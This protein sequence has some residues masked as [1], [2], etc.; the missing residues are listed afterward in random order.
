MPPHCPFSS[1][2]PSL[3][4]S[5]HR[6][7]FHL[8]HPPSTF[9]FVHLSSSTSFLP[10]FAHPSFLYSSSPPYI[11]TFPF[12]TSSLHLSL[13]FPVILFHF[14]PP[15]LF[16][17]SDL[18][19]SLL[20]SFLRESYVHFSS[21]HSLPSCSSCQTSLPRTPLYFPS[22]PLLPLLLEVFSLK[23][24]MWNIFS[25]RRQ[26]LKILACDVNLACD[27]I[28]ACIMW[29]ILHAQ[30]NL[31]SANIYP[32]YLLLHIHLLT[33]TPHICFFLYL[34][35]LSPSSLPIHYSYLLS[36]PIYLSIM[37]PYLE[38]STPLSTSLASLLSL[39]TL[40]HP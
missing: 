34:P 29:C 35:Y 26:P 39:P 33:F 32:L 38:P 14:I 24:N 23:W 28:L 16:S 25:P 1:S 22:Y 3:V 27:V 13:R 17:S 9:H 12:F 20:F 7:L 4:S 30:P 11:P 6:Y 2:Y 19:V 31:S 15:P 8:S 37:L 10:F 18:S 36:N 40:S 5:V 21:L